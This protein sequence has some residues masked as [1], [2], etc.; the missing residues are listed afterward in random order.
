MTRIK[1]RA[2]RTYHFGAVT[3][4]V[5]G[6]NARMMVGRDILSIPRST[7]CAILRDYRRITERARLAVISALVAI[8]PNGNWTD[9]DSRANAYPLLDL[10]NAIECLSNLRRE[11]TDE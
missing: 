7:A 11:A 1:G 10:E 2:G 8:D 6:R 9:E 4:A 5:N 3:V